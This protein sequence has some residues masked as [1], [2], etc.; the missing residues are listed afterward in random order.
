MINTNKLGD[1]FFITLSYK[2]LQVF[3]FRILISCD[4]LKIK[5]LHMGENPVTSKGMI[6]LLKS[7]GHNDSIKDLYINDICLQNDTVKALSKMLVRNTTLTHLNL[8]NCG[9]DDES[10]LILKTGLVFNSSLK[11]K[12]KYCLNYR[13]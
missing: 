3:Y 1:D 4:K 8:G 13:C 6:P 12:H 7:I 11:V 9:I 5:T 10:V 2:V